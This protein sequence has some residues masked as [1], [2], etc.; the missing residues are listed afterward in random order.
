MTRIDPALLAALE[1]YG[2]G[3]YHQDPPYTFV[4]QRGEHHEV[5][6]L[7]EAC[8]QARNLLEGEELWMKKFEH[9]RSR[10]LR[11]GLGAIFSQIIDGKL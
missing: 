11:L 2:K 6:S 9:L 4:F 3:R 10:M 5:F 7:E 8:N 1:H